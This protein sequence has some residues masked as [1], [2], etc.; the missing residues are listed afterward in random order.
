MSG[1]KN[2]WLQQPKNL[3]VDMNVQWG[4][5][6]EE[7]GLLSP[8]WEEENSTERIRAEKVQGKRSL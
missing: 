3:P 7:G 2:K 5:Q 6:A 8:V 4:S 1:K